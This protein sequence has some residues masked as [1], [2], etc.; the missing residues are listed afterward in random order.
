MIRES[1]RSVTVLGCQFAQTAVSGLTAFYLAVV[2][3]PDAYGKFV[4]ISTVSAVA[5]L[6]AG[7][8]TEHVLIM[9]GSRDAS[10]V[11]VYFGNA[12]VVRLILSVLLSIAGGALLWQLGGDDV[13]VWFLLGSGSFVAAFSNPLFLA[14][15][16]IQNHHVRPWVFCL[17]GSA[18]FF[19]YVAVLGQRATLMNIA[20]GFLAAQI[21]TA[22]L[23]VS[24][25]RRRVR[26]EFAIDEMRSCLR[27]GLIF[28]AS[29]GC[30][31]LFAR[32]DIFL[33]QLLCGPRSLGVYSVAQ[34]IASMFQMI[35]SSLNIVELPEFHR[36][37]AETAALGR[38][39][40]DLRR[41]LLEI[42]M[43]VYGLIVLNAA[44]IVQRVFP[45]DY[46][47]ATPVLIILCANGLVLFVNYPYYMLMEALKSIRARMYAR[48]LTVLVT[49]GA[50]MFG[51]QGLGA[52]GA[53]YG[54]LFGQLVFFA[55]LHWLTRSANGGLG[56]LATDG[57]VVALCAGSLTIAL[58]LQNALLS[59]PALAVTTSLVY[60]AIVLGIGLPLH[61]LRSYAYFLP[62]TVGASP[63][64]TGPT[65]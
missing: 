38:R 49:A 61:L 6:F 12:L 17:A 11:P 10:L 51:I 52:I 53:A 64:C 35:P 14:V 65:Y 15:Y 24:D 33:V 23:F 9:E 28:A 7:L 3:T 46:D 59:P 44:F 34:R 32:M 19:V 25:F 54:L 60:V 26:V 2:L 50:I 57:K 8:G 36:A 41:I 4:F 31:Y 21:V 63:G 40:R 43:L 39:F 62:R 20:A 30:D 22:L 47:D 58:L 42:G 18:L 16:R 48:M 1:R 27:K 13:G 5:P 56:A 55:A 29:Q 37:A 45:A